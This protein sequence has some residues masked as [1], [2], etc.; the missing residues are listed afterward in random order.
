MD[1]VVPGLDGLILAADIDDDARPPP[2][3]GA[4][5]GEELLQPLRLGEQEEVLGAEQHVAVV[6]GEVPGGLRQELVER[7]GLRRGPVGI[8]APDQ[9]GDVV[10]AEPPEGGRWIEQ[11]RP[12]QRHPVRRQHFLQE[13]AAGLGRAD[14]DD[15]GRVHGGASLFAG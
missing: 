4:A 10:V 7:L 1:L 9:E 11:A 2:L 8:A 3:Q 12:A 13:G 5:L 14:V 15:A 6:A